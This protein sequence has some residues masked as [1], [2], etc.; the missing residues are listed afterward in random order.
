MQIMAQKWK[1]KQERQGREGC[2]GNDSEWMQMMQGMKCF[3]GQG[4]GC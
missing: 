1:Q 3:S 2:H 4:F